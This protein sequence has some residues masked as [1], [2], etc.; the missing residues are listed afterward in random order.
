[1]MNDLESAKDGFVSHS[2]RKLKLI[3]KYI[4]VLEKYSSYISSH[5]N[6]RVLSNDTCETITF[7]NLFE[8]VCKSM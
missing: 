6:V 7:Y 5:G 1:M 2:L 3:L 4:I 8:L